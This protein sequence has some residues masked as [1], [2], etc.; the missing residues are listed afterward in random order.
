ME[1]HSQDERGQQTYSS[2]TRKVVMSVLKYLRRRDVTMNEGKLERETAT[3][4]STSVRSIQRM[5]KEMK[6]GRL[7]SPSST[8][9]RVA[10]VLDSVDQFDERCIR[11]EILS[12]YTRGEIPTTEAILKRVKEPPVCFPG[13][14]TSLKKIMKRII[15]ETMRKERKSYK[16]GIGIKPTCGQKNMNACVWVFIYEFL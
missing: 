11:D 6:D 12:F 10:P 15:W 13:E 3:A 2:Q 1:Q 9:Q 16:N 5:K 8:R 7:H 14:K 4:T